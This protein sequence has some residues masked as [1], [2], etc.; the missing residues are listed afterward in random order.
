[1]DIGAVRDAID[2]DGPIQVSS[3]HSVAE[4]LILFLD[5]F[6]DPVIPYEHYPVCLEHCTHFANSKRALRSMDFSHRNVFKYIC[7]FLREILSHSELNRS[8]AKFLSQ[9]FGDVLLKPQ[10]PEA[11]NVA[12]STSKKRSLFVYQF[13]TNDYDE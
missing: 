5:S 7:A 11:G 4:S 10:L 3:I 8:N 13:L 6:P 9:V 2:T 1:M 12:K